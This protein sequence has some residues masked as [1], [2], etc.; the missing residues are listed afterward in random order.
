MTR[1]QIA[2]FTAGASLL[3]LGLGAPAQASYLTSILT[4]DVT[5][6]FED[7]SRE[8]F[9][10]TNAD[11]LF[12]VGDILTGFIRIDDKTAPDAV[13]IN[14]SIYAIFSQEVVAVT[15]GIGGP[16]VQFGAVTSDAG[17]TLAALGVTGAGAADM[18]AVYSVFGGFSTNLI[19]ASPGER[20]GSATVTLADYLDLITAEGTLDIIAGI[21]DTPACSGAAGSD[22]DCFQG[23]GIL[24]RGGSTSALIG[25][26]STLTVGN[27]VGGLET[28]LDPSGYTID[29]TTPAGS[30]VPP[31]PL[32]VISELSISNGAARGTSGSVN[33]SE[34]IDGSE[35]TNSAQCI[36]ANGVNNSC[37]FINDADFGFVPVPEPVSIAMLGAGLLGLGATR[38]RQRQRKN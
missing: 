34:W 22:A 6:I 35:L 3:L 33:E 8:A 17:L 2:G 30:F 18:I 12:G 32:F 21:Y 5:N 19:L 26:P 11:G 24:A 29:D 10:D 14:N 38:R 27:F 23:T 9:F 7:Q 28:S 36:D 15:V 31:A 1:K 16:A 25:L 37:G 20:T 4:S 13:A